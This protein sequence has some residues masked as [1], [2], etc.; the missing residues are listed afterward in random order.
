MYFEKVA[1][2]TFLCDKSKTHLQWKVISNLQLYVRR[3]R[4]ARAALAPLAVR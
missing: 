2:I 1:S 4:Q 3:W